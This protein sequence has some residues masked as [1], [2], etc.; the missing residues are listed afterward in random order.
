MPTYNHPIDVLLLCTANQCRSPMAEALLRHRLVG[1]AADVHVTSA[2]LLAGGASATDHARATM[3]ARDLDLSGHKSRR[4]DETMIAGADLIV[5]MSREHVR[6]VAVL[7]PDALARTFTLKEL[8]RASDAA[9]PRRLGE[10]VAE[11]IVRI[12]VDRQRAALVG[13]RHDPELDI[14]DPVGGSRL[15]YETTAEELD[16]LL[17]ELVQVI[18]PGGTDHGQE[19]SA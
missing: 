16:H 4:V 12:G 6:E 5:A 17:G 19:R 10:D 8:I 18:W 11:W 2:G 14:A 13:L 9:G 1:V 7:S 15:D 3:A